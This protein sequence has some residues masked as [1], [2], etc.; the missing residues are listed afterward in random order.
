MKE[1]A[2]ATLTAVAAACAARAQQ[3]PNLCQSANFNENACRAAVKVTVLQWRRLGTATVPEV[4]LLLRPLPGLPIGW[5]NSDRRTRGH[6]PGNAAA[7][8]GIRE[9]DT[10]IATNFSFFVPH[11]FD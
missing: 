9:S 10:P 2:Q 1:S 6:E 5:R 11:L 3:A 7:G 8:M 4:S